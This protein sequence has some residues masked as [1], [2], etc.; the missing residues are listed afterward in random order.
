MSTTR[1]FYV[2]NS[3]WFFLSH[4]LPLALEAIRRGYEVY[5]L[6]KN[7]G[8]KEEIESY[9]IRFID[10]EFERSGRNPFKDLRLIL[11]LNK[12]YR[13]YQ[14][15]I[16]HHVTIKPALYGTI[17]ANRLTRHRP[18]VVN[19]VTGLG[20]VFADKRKS[21]TRTV[22]QFLMNYAYKKQRNRFIFQNPDD[23]RMYKE[24][25]YLNDRNHKIIK[26]AGV[27][28]TDYKHTQPAEKD[29]L[30]IVFPAR[31]LYDKGLSEF[32][33]AAEMLKSTY[34]GRVLFSLVGG[35][36]VHN[37]AAITEA[38]LKSLLVPGFIEW[39]GHIVDMKPEYQRAD[40]VCLPSYG[41]GLP[42]SLVEA[43]AIGRP[44]VTTNVAGCKECVEEG[45]NGFIVPMKNVEK[46]AEAI[47][48][49]INDKEM[50]LRMGDASRRMMEKE[51]SLATVVRETFD[52]YN[53]A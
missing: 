40:I 21:I 46:L 51:M 39:S 1:I 34:E 13:E 16:I 28:T 10:V 38:G 31:M 32:V 41:E 19:A 27:D 8:R 47:E 50:R 7:T 25:G 11:E 44:I 45:V 14:P 35:I 52:F 9:G 3:D 22:I 18:L 2:V 49:L 20:Y 33:K 43:M 24:L 30:H 6:S 17:A 29:K 12:I 4:R 37:P 23:R 26:G 36:D 15:Q 48:K 53:P 42:K 5:L